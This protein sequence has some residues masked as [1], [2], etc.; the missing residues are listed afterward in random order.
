MERKLKRFISWNVNGL[1]AA[2]KKGF[3]HSMEQL[4]ADIIAIQEI[5]TKPEQLPD[6]LLTIKDYESL[7]YP[8]QKPGYAGVALYTRNE[9]LNILYGLDD[10]RFNREGRVLTTEFE[11]YYFINVYFPNAQPKLKRLDYKLAFNEELK[12]FT[13]RLCRQKSVIVCGDFNV[14]HKEI[15]LKN[16]KGNKYNPGF[17]EPERN[18]MDLFV[19]EDYVDTFRMFNQDPGQYTWWSYRFNARAKNIGWRLDYFC[20]D[21]QSK[22]RVKGAGILKQIMGSDHCPIELLFV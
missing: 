11:D 9:P 15:D 8:A 17:S 22:K 3:V 16:P 18:W 21:R 6:E 19:Q 14:A 1:R 13:D 5:K 4:D 7:W 2:V 20:V 10:D 12:M